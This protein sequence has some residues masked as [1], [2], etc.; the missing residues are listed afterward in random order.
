MLY[1]LFAFLYE[2]RK[3]KLNNCGASVE[4]RK[5][6]NVAGN[7]LL[8][9][10]ETVRKFL[11]TAKNF[12][13]QVNYITE[14]FK[15]AGGGNWIQSNDF[16]LK[17]NALELPIKKAISA[18]RQ[19]EIDPPDLSEGDQN[20]I[21]WPTVNEFE[22]SL[23]A[24]K[25]IIDNFSQP[26]TD[27]INHFEV[28]LSSISESLSL[29]RDMVN[30]TYQSLTLFSMN[31]NKTDIREHYV[32]ERAFPVLYSI[33]SGTFLLALKGNCILSGMF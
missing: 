27:F 7:D 28:E 23:T 2:L 3:S 18:L 15:T 25:Q 33:F 4:N 11:I 5:A 1:F 6:E 12:E 20:E 21:D 24:S 8:E 22:L 29:Y 10:N 26:N 19:R 13:S 16:V 32:L 30:K 9:P 14:R 31:L 17:K